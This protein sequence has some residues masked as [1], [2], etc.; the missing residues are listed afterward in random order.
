MVTDMEG[1]IQE[2][3][4]PLRIEGL[5]PMREFPRITS[6]MSFKEG[7]GILMRRLG[8][9]TDKVRKALRDRFPEGVCGSGDLHAHKLNVRHYLQFDIIFN[10]ILHTG[11]EELRHLGLGRKYL[12]NRIQRQLC[13]GLC[14][15]FDP[16]GRTGDYP[17]HSWLDEIQLKQVDE[18]QLKVLDL[19]DRKLFRKRH[20]LQVRMSQMSTG[21]LKALLGHLDEIRRL[22]RS[23]AAKDSELGLKAFGDFLVNFRKEF[24]NRINGELL[25]SREV[26]KKRKSMLS[27]WGFRLSRIWFMSGKNYRFRAYERLICQQAHRTLRKA[28]TDLRRFQDPDIP[29]WYRRPSDEDWNEQ[30][31]KDRRERKIMTPRK[32]NQLGRYGLGGIPGL[33]EPIRAEDFGNLRTDWTIAEARENYRLEQE[34]QERLKSEQPEQPEG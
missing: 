4:T 9:T 3:R 10:D 17:I 15:G 13:A 12:I 7:I 23:L 28:Q 30:I 21:C 8:L 5:E 1:E 6:E 19:M 22:V 31:R 34:R 16:T 26:F 18:I 14:D 24:N 33:T 2:P 32:K 20:A 25:R 27:Y 11:F 29:N